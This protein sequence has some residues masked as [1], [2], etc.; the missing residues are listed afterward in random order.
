MNGQYS[1]FDINQKTRPWEYG[2][3]RYI[4]QK[5]DIGNEDGERVGT[6]TE[7]QPYYTIINVDGRLYV[8][9]P[10]TCRPAGGDE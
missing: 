10:T 4:G 9:T 5:V 6:I 8:G 2:W 3:Q 1:I 7:I